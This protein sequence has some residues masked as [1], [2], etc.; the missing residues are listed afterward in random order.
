MPFASWNCARHG[1]VGEVTRVFGLKH[2]NLTFQGLGGGKDKVDLC[3]SFA[4][5]N[6]WTLRTR[7]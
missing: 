1:E 6:R 4:L 3:G 2:Q 7:F 5:P